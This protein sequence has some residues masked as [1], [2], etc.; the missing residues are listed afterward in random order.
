VLPIIAAIAASTTIGV[1]AERRWGERAASASHRALMFV[2]Y[3]VLPPVAFLNLTRADL[4]ANAGAGIVLALMALVALSLLA[5]A[6]GTHLLGLR[7]AS[8][9]AIVVSVLTV[10]TGYLGYA[11][12]A[13]LLGF[14]QLGEAAAYDVLVSGPALLFGGFALGA[15]FG[16]D[17]G[18]GLRGRTRS[19]FTRN[20]ALYAALA[21]L[22]A[23]D[24]LAPEVLVDISRVVVVCVLPLGFFAVGVAL[25]SEAETGRVA[26]PP[27]FDRPVAA[28]VGLRLVGGP[29]VLYA[30]ALPLTELPET[31]LLLA[32]MPCGINTMIVAHAYG[33]DLRIAAGA[34]AWS[35]AIAVAGLSV[36]AL[37]R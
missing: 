31:Y 35:T 32:A 2:L 28:V 17:A 18:E 22:V 14:D 12:V 7:R 29:L 13:A 34:I 21:A 4:D 5:Y 15:A 37:V 33:L 9:G 24:A 3:G 23:P 20:P 1:W 36:F 10:N 27:P 6:V 8:V 30:L 16:A 25:A 19:F 26:F 11:V